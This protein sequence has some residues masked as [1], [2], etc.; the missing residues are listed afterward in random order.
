M[1]KHTKTARELADMIVMKLAVAGI[2]IDVHGDTAGWHVVAHGSTP[3][4][5]AQAQAEAD[6]IAQNLR[7]AYDLAD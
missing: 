3:E 4:R 5:V 2:R 1:E 7:V 6:R